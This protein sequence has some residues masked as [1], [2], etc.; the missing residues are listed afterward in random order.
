MVAGLSQV[1]KAASGYFTAPVVRILARTPVTPNTLTWFGFALAVAAAALI[2]TGYLLIAGLVVILGGYFDMLDGALARRTN[3][4]SRFGSILDSTL[5]RVSEGV[6]LLGVLALFSA[7]G[8][9]TGILLRTEPHVDIGTLLV[10]IVLISS[11]LVSYIRAKAES[12]GLECMVGVFT[13]PERVI[14]LALGLLI[15]QIEIALGVI[16]AFSFITVGQ[17]LV[18]VWRQVK[19]KESRGE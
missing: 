9:D 6:L 8:S 3:R 2:A 19:D 13:R 5:D 10:G 1:R 15:D 14:V 7:R 11:M 16:A 4:V 17:R 12:L 18:Y